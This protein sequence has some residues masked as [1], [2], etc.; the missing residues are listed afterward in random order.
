MAMESGRKA[1][2]VRERHL[3]LMGKLPA[4]TV[5]ILVHTALFVG[6]ANIT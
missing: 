6:L 3:K 2:D 1:G 5:P 4:S